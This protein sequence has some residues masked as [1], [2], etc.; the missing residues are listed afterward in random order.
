M[1][2]NGSMTQAQIIAARKAM[3]APKVIYTPALIRQIKKRMAQG[4]PNTGRIS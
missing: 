4:R 3:R 2:I 1:G